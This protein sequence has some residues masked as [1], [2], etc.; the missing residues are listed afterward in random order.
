VPTDGPVGDMLRA[1]NRHAMRPGHLHVMVQKP[2][3]DTLITHVFVQGDE[4][5]DSDA[6]FG[7]RGSCIGEYVRHEPG[8]A[9]DG[10]VK[11]TAFF[12][13]DQA[14]SLAPA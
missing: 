11:D 3:F 8:K 7:V 5:L 4:Y 6:V 14:V 13:L 2:G 12:T 9:P 1:S 10:T